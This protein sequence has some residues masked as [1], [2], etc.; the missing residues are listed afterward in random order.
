MKLEHMILEVSVLVVLNA[1]TYKN[2]VKN[3]LLVSLEKKSTKHCS[4]CHAIV[5]QACKR[6]YQLL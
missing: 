3:I 1:C 2:Y 4:M 5:T 6:Y